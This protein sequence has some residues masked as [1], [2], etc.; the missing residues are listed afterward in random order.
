MRSAPERPSTDTPPAR[1]HVRLA[2]F[3]R[4]NHEAILKA[5]EAFARTL[6]PAAEGMSK[7]RLRDH[8]D[9][10][11]KAI[12]HDMN[13]LQT[14]AEEQAKSSRINSTTASKRTASDG[15]RTTSRKKP[16]DFSLTL[17]S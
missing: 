15:R 5:W 12:V 2:D 10:I 14:T 3:I 17:R 11:L 7:A 13:S 8:A 1:R 9:E 6:L 4:G 16:S